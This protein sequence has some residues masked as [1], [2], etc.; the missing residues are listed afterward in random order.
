MLHKNAAV[1]K[2]YESSAID[3]TCADYI[4]RKCKFQDELE[5]NFGAIRYVFFLPLSPLI[6][7]TS[8]KMSSQKMLVKRSWFEI[9]NF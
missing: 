3:Y 8:E 9:D 5:D 2:V 7:S 4:F 6:T 1:H